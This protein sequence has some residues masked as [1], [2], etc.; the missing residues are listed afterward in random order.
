LELRKIIEKYAEPIKES[1]KI[2]LKEA[3][4]EVKDFRK[5][6]YARKYLKDT[7]TRLIKNKMISNVM[8]KII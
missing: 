8:N 6:N 2:V 3:A 7:I 1:S 5:K 4:K